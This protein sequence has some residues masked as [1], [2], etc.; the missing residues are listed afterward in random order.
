MDDK[1]KNVAIIFLTAGEVPAKNN[2]ISSQVLKLAEYFHKSNMFEKVE[3]F[4]LVPRRYLLTSFLRRRKTDFQFVHNFGF[5]SKLEKTFFIFG[6]F[7]EF[8]FHKFFAKADAKKI[9]QNI[10]L[11][12]SATIIFH[13]RSYYATNVAL[14]V[15]ENLPTKNIK[16]LFDMRS[17]LPPEFYFVMGKKGKLLYAEAKEWES[18]LVNSADK[19]LMTTHGGIEL[20]KIENPKVNIGY[21][22]IMGLDTTSFQYDEEQFVQRWNKKQISYVGSVSF[23]HPLHM[24]ENLLFFLNDCFGNAQIEIATNSV[25]TKTKITIKNIAHD[26]ILSYYQNMLALVIPGREVN[27]FFERVQLNLNLFSTKASEAISAGVPLIVNENIK[28]LAEFVEKNRC[29]II[30]RSSEHG[31]ELVNCNINDITNKEFWR[32]LTKNMFKI[33]ESFTFHSVEKIYRNYYE[34][35]VFEG[36]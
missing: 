7:F 13:C 2:L 20:L 21:I 8:I 3:Y 16:V 26:E 29:G 23:W 28:E 25:N 11:N 32:K 30:F 6:G 31:I 36:K 5:H 19:S 27:G 15:K 35:I 1:F 22:P 9:I 10:S 18:Y 24:I 12:Q 34:E 17:L 4:G 14:I 33:A